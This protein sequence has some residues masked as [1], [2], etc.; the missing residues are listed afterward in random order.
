MDPESNVT[1]A[2]RTAELVSTTEREPNTTSS[3]TYTAEGRRGEENRGKESRGEGREGEES[4][5]EGRRG[6]QRG[7]EG[8]RSCEMVGG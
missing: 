1:L 7:G 5:I 8:R 6:E 3:P 2:D 4:R